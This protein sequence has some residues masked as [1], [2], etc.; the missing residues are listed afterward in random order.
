MPSF[1]Y[2]VRDRNGAISRGEIEAAGIREAA[3]K[4]R[5]QGLFISSLRPA[6]ESR[7]QSERKGA[8]GRVRRIALRDLLLF[9]RQFAVL[10]RA[11]VN[12]SACLKIM[13]EQAENPLL[14]EVITGIRR[15][16]ESGNPLHQ[17]LERFPKVFPSIYIHMVEAGETGG[18]LETVLERLAEYFEREFMLRKKIIGALAYP[19]VIAVV[20]VIAV[21]LVMV[22]IMPV[23]VEMFTEAGV[24]LPGPTKVLIAISNFLSAYW[25][26]FLFLAVAAGVGFNFY[27]KTPQGKMAIDRLLYRMKI[28]GPVVQKTVVAR[29][30]RLLATLLDSGILITTS[31]EIVERAVANGVIASSVA[32]ARVNL[33]KGSGLAGPL[34][35]TGVYP[36]MVTQMIAVGEE[37]GELSTMLNEIADFY[38]KEAGYAVEGLTA[39]IEPAVI[40]LMGLAVG[41]IVIS[42]VMPM[43]QLSSGAAL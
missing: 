11:G 18:Q 36:A 25:Y 19:V 26:L 30:S 37:T 42:V 35:D 22:L 39:M 14:A 8:G 15:D 33:T 38:E 27:R 12:L 24:E 1:V 4:L 21:V 31:L 2:Q 43:M 10:I 7:A 41:V 6:G 34:A 3:A 29:F 16:V 17:A 32:K 9:T 23:F 13:E 28:I 20:A 5:D 40:I